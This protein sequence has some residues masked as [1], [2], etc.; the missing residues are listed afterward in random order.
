[1]RGSIGIYCVVP[2]LTNINI[3]E[4]VKEIA[5]I[6]VLGF[7]KNEV[8]AYVFREIIVLTLFGAVI[9]LPLGKLLHSFVM[10]QIKIDMVSFQNIITPLSYVISIA[11]T[12]VFAAIIN[13]AMARKL[14]KIDMAQSLKSVE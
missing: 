14:D 11:L 4:R 13:I 10:A 3:N 9:G 6:K 12:L 8:S 7:Y 5:T 2:T 1:M